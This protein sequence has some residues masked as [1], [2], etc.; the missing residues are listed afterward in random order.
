MVTRYFLL[1]STVLGILTVNELHQSVTETA[2]NVYDN[3][4]INPCGPL[5]LLYGY[6]CREKMQNKRLFSPGLKTDYLLKKDGNTS[7]YTRNGSRD[8]PN[9]FGEDNEATS[10]YLVRYYKALKT[11]YNVSNGETAI[12]INRKTSL[13]KLLTQTLSRHECFQLLATMLLIAEGIKVPLE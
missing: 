4:Y 1:L 10:K 11:M 13:C 9:M 5:N 6:L 12:Y 3:V 7:T 2:S 8:V